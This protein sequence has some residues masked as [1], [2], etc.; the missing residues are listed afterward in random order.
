MVERMSMA[1]IRNYWPDITEGLCRA[2]CAEK[3]LT[4]DMFSSV[5]K[6]CLTGE[7]Q[8]WSVSGYSDARNEVQ[9]GIAIT[10]IIEE[11]V[12]KSRALMIYTIFSHH[13][14]DI[15]LLHEGYTVLR[16]FARKQKCSAILS[17]SNNKKGLE[18]AKLFGA[19]TTR[20]HLVLDV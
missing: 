12:L 20:R 4:T 3:Y 5:L 6:A 8:V 1:D 17:F 18:L 13:A 16:E 14:L 9:T 10:T 11:K 2:L 15:K 19:A 7:F